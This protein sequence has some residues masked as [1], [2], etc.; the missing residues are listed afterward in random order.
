MDSTTQNRCGSVTGPVVDLKARLMLTVTPQGGGWYRGELAGR[1]GLLVLLDH[2]YLCFLISLHCETS[3]TVRWPAGPS[4]PAPEQMR[5]FLL[6]PKF[7]LNISL[8]THTH[9]HTHLSTWAH[10]HTHT[11]THTHNERRTCC[12]IE[13]KIRNYFSVCVCVCVCF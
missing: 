5:T 3:S 4:N 2:F 10:T 7:R 13:V 11:H 12:H 9:A 6:E 8:C 1:S